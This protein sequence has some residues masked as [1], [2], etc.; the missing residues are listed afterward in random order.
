VAFALT[1]AIAE[2]SGSV[3]A[4]F[5]GEL[6]PAPLQTVQTFRTVVIGILGVLGAVAPCFVHPQCVVVSVV[7]SVV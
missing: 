1:L 5:V 4:T 2:V 7:V 3:S 6:F